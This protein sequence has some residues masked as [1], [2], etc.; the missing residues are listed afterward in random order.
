[1]AIAYPNIRG[2]LV[3][4]T[5]TQ[6]TTFRRSEPLE[7]P[8]YLK[9]LSDDAPVFYNLKFKFNRADEAKIFY[10]WVITNNIYRGMPFDCPIGT[11]FTGESEAQQTQEVELTEGDLR[12]WTNNGTYFEFEAT[13]RARQEVTGLEDLYDFIAG[14][15]PCDIAEGNEL[16]ISVNI[17][18]PEA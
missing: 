13:F 8:A 15:D 11:P 5:K 17:N 7:G 10:A 18:L 9:T 14:E 3:S 1:M 12:S 16:D 2:P 6:S 4:Q